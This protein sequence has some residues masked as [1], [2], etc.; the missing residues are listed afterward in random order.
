MFY[1]SRGEGGNTTH[2]VMAMARKQYF[3]CTGQNSDLDQQGCR[4]QLEELPNAS[5]LPPAS[6]Q[7]LYERG[8]NTNDFD[9]SLI[10]LF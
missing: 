8:D 6:W 9:V 7:G 4:C 10:I 1:V 5:I 3:V 2:G